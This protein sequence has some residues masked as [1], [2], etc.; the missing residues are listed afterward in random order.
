M[1]EERDNRIEP[2]RG[3]VLD[4][5]TARKICS[6]QQPGRGCLRQ[7]GV[8]VKYMAPVVPSRQANITSL[9]RRIWSTPSISRPVSQ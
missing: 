7:N 3:A 1:F 5:I 9:A 6:A 2:E 8:A 4:H